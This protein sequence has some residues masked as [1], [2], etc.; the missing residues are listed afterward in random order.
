MKL[1]NFIDRNALIIYFLLAYLIS[2]GAILIIVGPGGLQP[3][4]ERLMGTVLL[5]FLAML[6]GPSLSG[7][8][9]TAYLE[10]RTGLRGMLARW[11]PAG[12]DR[13]WYA[14]AL[15]TAPLLLLL[16][17]GLLS[18]VSPVFVPG[19]IAS[20]DKGMLLAF[21]LTVGLLAGFFEEIGWSGFAAPR[22][23][24]GR[25]WL[26][27]GL[28]LGVLWG[29]WHVL[30]DYWGNA[31]LYGELYWMRGLLWVVTLTAYRTLMVWVYRRSGSLLIMQLMHAAFTGGQA[32]LEPLF[33]PPDYLVWYGL[34]A[35]SLWVLV[36]ILALRSQ[37]ATGSV[38]DPQGTHT[39]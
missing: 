14:V 20:P 18:L 36:A 16:V 28:I 25:G 15:L 32:L 35:A 13:R 7:I 30:A 11:R 5:V 37:N 6:L 34:F 39:L 8:G 31:A 33:A 23:L 26:A 4:A 22:L 17:G 10:G 38:L 21:G 2:W 9:L 1:K 29:I 3:A 27:A 24:Q 19:I 12:L